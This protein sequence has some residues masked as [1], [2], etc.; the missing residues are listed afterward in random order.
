VIP[1][2]HVWLVWA[3]A[4]LVPWALLYWRF[5][6]HRRAM[7]W[8]SV[9]TTPFGLTEPLFVPSYWNPP[10][11]FDL[12]QRT[13]FDIESLIFCF[14]IGGVGAV[15]ANVLTRRVP[16]PV[17]PSE[18]HHSRH[19]FHLWALL[20]PF[21]VFVLLL[22]LGWN[23][24]YPAIIAM[25][26]GAGFNLLCRPDLTRSTLLGGGVFVVYY[27]TFLA[28]LEVTAPSGY[29]A[30][31]WNLSALSGIMLGFMPLEELLFA[32]AFGSFWAGV[33]EH[34]TWRRV[35]SRPSFT[36]P[37]TERSRHVA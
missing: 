35:T 8:A 7:I 20:A 21:V 34:Y 25:L 19:R 22:P 24:I 16:A 5:P 18:R 4:F 17:P 6:A 37:E 14:G 3:S 13:G 9:F 36:E 30:Q 15:M 23:H 33:Y 26:V 12:A 1:A 10:T 31:V 32:A 28:G 11:L 2:S 27:A 29:I